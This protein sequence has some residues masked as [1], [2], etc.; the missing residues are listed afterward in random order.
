VEKSPG[1]LFVTESKAFVFEKRP[2][3][4]SNKFKLVFWA[5]K[6]EYLDGPKFFIV[7]LLSPPFA[8]GRIGG[9]VVSI[10]YENF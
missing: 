8:K 5:A 4:P 6:S 3:G 9:I 2:T 1:V 7:M 10:S